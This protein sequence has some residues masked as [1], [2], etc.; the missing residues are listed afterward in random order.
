SPATSTPAAR[1]LSRRCARSRSRC[2]RRRGGSV[3]VS[4]SVELQ[5]VVELPLRDLL[6][7][8]LGLALLDVDEVVDVV[9]VTGLA[10]AG[11]QGGVAGQLTG[12]VEQVGRQQVDPLRFALG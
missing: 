10:E 3:P 6:V 12:G 1:R 4:C 7:G 5:V 2:A 8:G 9:P 11:A